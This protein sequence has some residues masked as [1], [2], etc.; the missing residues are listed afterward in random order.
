MGICPTNFGI[1]GE[2]M[3]EISNRQSKKK[4]KNCTKRLE[5]LQ[6]GKCLVK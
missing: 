6:G 2:L 1:T 5:W 3:T 4:K